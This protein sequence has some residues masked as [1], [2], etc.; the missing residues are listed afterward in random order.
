MAYYGVDNPA[1]FG[2]ICCADCNGGYIY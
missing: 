2:G 1:D